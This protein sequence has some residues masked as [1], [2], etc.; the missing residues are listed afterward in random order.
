VVVVVVH[1]LEALKQP[2]TIR[3]YEYSVA[4][5]QAAYAPSDSTAERT[6]FT[7]PRFIAGTPYTAKEGGLMGYAVGGP[8]E[9]MSAQNAIGGNTMYPQ[10]QLQTDMYSNPMVQRPMPTNVI[11]SGL[12]APVNTFT[13]SAK[14][15]SGGVFQFRRLF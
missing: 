12:D 11:Q 6:Y 2:G 13:V 8:V 10:S 4:Q 9:E 15:A 1:L 3:P 5:N 7:E 14:M